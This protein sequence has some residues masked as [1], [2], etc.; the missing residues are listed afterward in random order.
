MALVVALYFQD[1]RKFAIF[2]EPEKNLHPY[3][4]SRVMTMFK[5]ASEFKQILATTHNSEIVK[6]AGLENILFVCRDRNGFSRITKPATSMSE[7]SS[8]TIWALKISLPT[9]YWVYDIGLS[10]ALRS[11]KETMMKGSKR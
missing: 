10:N 6:Y 3:L 4:L 11:W 1:Q 7:Y 2:E 5:E 8:K 9:I